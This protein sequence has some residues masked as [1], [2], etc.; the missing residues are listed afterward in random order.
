M[1]EPTPEVVPPS[2]EPDAAVATG[3]GH[4]T[5]GA[6][7]PPPPSESAGTGGVGTAADQQGD[8][9]EGGAPYSLDGG[10]ANPTDPAS[11]SGT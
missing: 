2:S 7:P 8:T 1:T 5:G 10:D 3:S 9:A 11:P 4:E 6:T